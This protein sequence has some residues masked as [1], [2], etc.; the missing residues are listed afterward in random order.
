[1]SGQRAADQSNRDCAK[2]QT[3][4]PHAPPPGGYTTATWQ[5][6]TCDAFSL[7]RAR[8]ADAPVGA[9]WM[10]K[11]RDPLGITPRFEWRLGW[12]S[13]E[14]FAAG[15]DDAGRA[16]ALRGN[17]TTVWPALRAGGRIQRSGQYLR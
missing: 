10:P 9:A 4:L 2:D 11:N 17:E 13:D 16:G 15:C 5:L 1:M 12:T 6:E 14:P 8:R 7:L 3:T